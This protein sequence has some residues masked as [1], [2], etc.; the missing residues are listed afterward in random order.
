MCKQ[1]A[2]GGCLRTHAALQMGS[3]ALLKQEGK[4]KQACRAWLAGRAKTDLAGP[5]ILHEL[6][7]VEHV[8]AD[9]LAPLCRQEQG[10]GTQA[11][12]VSTGAE[13]A[14]SGP[15]TPAAGRMAAC[16][17]VPTSQTPSPAGSQSCQ[18]PACQ[19]R[20]L[21]RFH[22]VSPYLRNLLQLLLLGH[23]QKLGL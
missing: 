1:H 21:T 4:Q 14:G 9:L 17:A 11:G 18:L 22:K 20:S 6:V 16:G 12:H 15:G 8:V 5:H 19:P 13:A 3:D 23:H 2:A 7:R 10:S